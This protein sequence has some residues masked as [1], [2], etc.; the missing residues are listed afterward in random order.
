MIN[1]TEVN[2]KKLKQCGPNKTKPN[3]I[4]INQCNH[5]PA[6]TRCPFRRAHNGTVAMQGLWTWPGV[7]QLS[8][9]EVQNSSPRIPAAA[10]IHAL[11]CAIAR[12]MLSFEPIRLP[13]SS[14]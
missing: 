6:T 2:C 7:L 12:F 5:N 1:P 10:A 11:P 13:L 4:T 3:A 9:D 14:T 8:V